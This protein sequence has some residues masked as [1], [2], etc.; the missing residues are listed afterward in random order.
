MSHLRLARLELI[1]PTTETTENSES[2]ECSASLVSVLP[3]YQWLMSVFMIHLPCSFSFC[4]PPCSYKTILHFGVQGS[5]VSNWFAQLLLN[6]EH[7]LFCVTWFWYQ[8]LDEPSLG[9]LQGLQTLSSALMTGFWLSPNHNH[10][11]FLSQWCS[12]PEGHCGFFTLVIIFLI[13]YV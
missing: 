5:L 8:Y 7:H 9:L 4:T 13:I 12:V 1:L 3:C 10:F 6:F 2:R 11:Y